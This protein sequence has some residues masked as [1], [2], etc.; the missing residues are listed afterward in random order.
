MIELLEFI[1]STFTLILLGYIYIY[2]SEKLLARS[3]RRIG[4]SVGNMYGATQHL[5]NLTKTLFKKSPPPL[6]FSKA[7]L[8]DLFLFIYTAI[9]FVLFY[10]SI[11]SYNY[12]D[13][14]LIGLFLII[15]LNCCENLL[16]YTIAEKSKIEHIVRYSIN[17]IAI[18][19]SLCFAILIF[20]PIDFIKATGINIL[21]NSIFLISSGGVAFFAIVIVS[22]KS[23]LYSRDINFFSGFRA[24]LFYYI[25]EL[26]CISLL[27]FLISFFYNSIGLSRAETALFLTLSTLFFAFFLFVFA[28]NLFTRMRVSDADK[29]LI[30]YFLPF[31]VLLLVLYNFWIILLG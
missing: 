5:A 8:Q 16:A 9:P 12:T 29:L 23:N 3:Q 11:F 31:S 30:G 7:Y 14:L 20:Q 6:H 28:R 22:S 27:T 24:Q 25:R 26:Y 19:F 13:K 4:S 21:I 18:A 15:F 17:N 10:F 2:L 1:I